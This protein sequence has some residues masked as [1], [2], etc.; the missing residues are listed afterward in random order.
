MWRAPHKLRHDPE[1]MV[2]VVVQGA[3]STPGDRTRDQRACRPSEARNPRTRDQFLRVPVACDWC[4]SRLSI[5]VQWSRI[6]PATLVPQA[7][8]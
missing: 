2:I 5:F 7:L 4:L 1:V 6:R 3:G 8:N